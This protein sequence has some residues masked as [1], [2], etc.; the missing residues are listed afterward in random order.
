MKPWI[1]IWLPILN[2]ARPQPGT[3]ADRPQNLVILLQHI[4]CAA[5]ELPFSSN[6]N[7]GAMSAQELARFLE[8][9]EQS[10]SLTRQGDD[11]IGW[12]IVIRQPKYLCALRP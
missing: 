1:S 8:L 7:F 4:S 6:E 12:Q 5:F 3:G 2:T 9:L 10:G 11:Y